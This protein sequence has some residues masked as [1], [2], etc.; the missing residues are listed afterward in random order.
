MFGWEVV[1]VGIASESFR[2]EVALC[3]AHATESVSHDVVLAFDVGQL[4]TALF[5]DET[6]PHDAL[7]IESLVDQ[8]LMVGEDFYLL[9]EENV[10]ILL[11]GLDDTE[12]LSLSV[13]VYLV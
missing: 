7:S 11:Q 9:T 2:R 6:P 12:E 5:N 8:I 4:R 13:V 3:E 10:S 1:S